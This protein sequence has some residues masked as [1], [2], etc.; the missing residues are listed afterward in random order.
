MSSVEIANRSI[1]GTF[2]NGSETLTNGTTYYFPIG[3]AGALVES[4]QVIWDSSIVITSIQ[5]EDSNIEGISTTTA[6]NPGEWIPENPTTGAYIATEGAGV[7]VTGATIAV[8]GGAAGGAMI[9]LGNIGSKICRL[10]VVVGGTGGRLQIF[11]HGK[12]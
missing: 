10:A 5:I 9:H 7:T 12:E 6:G 1:T 8:A 4:V 2:N 11:P 3:S